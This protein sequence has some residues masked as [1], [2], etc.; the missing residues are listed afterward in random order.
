[1]DEGRFCIERSPARAL[2]KS[3]THPETHSD[4]GRIFSSGGEAS[5]T[6][7]SHSPIIDTFARTR[8]RHVDS[9]RPHCRR[10]RGDVT[11]NP[12]VRVFRD[13]AGQSPDR[14]RDRARWPGAGC[15][16]WDVRNLARWRRPALCRDGDAQTR[17]DWRGHGSTGHRREPVRPD[18]AIQGSGD[19]CGRNRW[20]RAG[21]ELGDRRDVGL[22]RHETRQ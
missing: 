10:R 18:L 20:V 13:E 6:L 5:I 3:S 21:S 12:A 17:D 15:R 11:G 7:R 22:F 2:G 1:M 4:F 9:V 19:A 16:A 14:R 8:L